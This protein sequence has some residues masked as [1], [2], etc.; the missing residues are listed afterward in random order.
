MTYDGNGLAFCKTPYYITK[1]MVGLS[2]FQNTD[3]RVLDTG[4]GDGAFI[5]ALI[6]KGFTNITGIELDDKLCSTCKDKYIDTTVIHGDFLTYPFKEPFDLIVGNPPYI[7]YNDLTE[8]LKQNVLSIVSTAESDIYYAFI[9]RSVS[10]LKDGE[11]L[12]YIVP[13]SF[14]YNTYAKNLRKFLSEA[15]TIDLII[16]L[17]E[18]KL[19]KGESPETI[20]LRFIKGRKADYVLYL[21]TK[22]TDCTDKDIY[23]KAL[24]AISR[25]GENDLFH[26]TEL[27]PF[28]GDGPWTLQPQMSYTCDIVSLGNIAKVGVGFVSGCDEAFLLKDEDIWNLSENEIQCVYPFAKAKYCK[29]FVLDE[30]AW[31]FIIPDEIQTEEQLRVVF[32]KFYE[33]L[34]HYADKLKK[35]YLSDK[36]KWWDWQA[37]WNYEFLYQ[38]FYRKRIYVPTLSRSKSL[39]F[40][41]GRANLFPSVDVL[42]IQPYK[43]DDI[44][45]LTAYLNSRIFQMY[46]DGLGIRRG[47]RRVITQR[48]FE[49]VPVPVFDEQDKTELSYLCQGGVEA[50]DDID[51]IVRKYIKTEELNP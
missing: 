20:I 33:K 46:Y 13:Y 32:P 47:G 28:S 45:W 25:K 3:V 40:S 43:P 42:F 51:S 39:N 29:P 4:C 38:N 23:E 15:G 24:D 14:L 1:L 16:D 6:E 48:L 37:L 35:R 12:I 22:K 2:Q 21:K 49:T 34:S 50:L 18:T 9:M 41:I 26:Y 11:E 30:C 36:K 10:L 8:V 17:D 27:K 31:Y 19:F 5:Q 44:Y 7:H